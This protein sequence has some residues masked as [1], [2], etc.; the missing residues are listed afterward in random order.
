MGGGGGTVQQVLY[1]YFVFVDVEELSMR[2]IA[3]FH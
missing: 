2:Y 3:V 1:K